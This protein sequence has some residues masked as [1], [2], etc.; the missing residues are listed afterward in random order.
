MAL[1][2]SLAGC[3]GG[4]TD[5]IAPEPDFDNPQPGNGGNN[6]GGNNGGGDGNQNPDNPSAS[7]SEIFISTDKTQLLTGKDNTI[8]NIRVTDK[9]GGIVAGVPVIINIAGSRSYGL[10][11]DGP[12]EQ[13]TDEKGLVTVE[14]LQSTVGIDSQLNH[15]TLLTVSI[16]NKSNVKQTFPIL[17]SGTRASNVVSTKNSVN[18]ND[19]FRIVGQIVDGADKPVTNADVILFSNDQQAGTGRLDSNGNFAFDLSAATLTPS[20]DNYIFSIEVK[21]SAI[22][23]RIPDI[24]TI[25]STNPSNLGFSPVNDIIV[26]NRQVVVLNVPDANNGDN[27]TLST[28]KGEI[29]VSSN[30]TTGSSRRILTVAN[31]QVVFYVESNVPGSA[32]ITAEYGTDSKETVLS[33]VSIQPKKLILQIERNV[34]SVGSATSVVA[35]VLDKDDAPVKNA[36]VQFT[37]IR[38][39]SGGNLSKAVAITNSN[40]QAMVTY[41]AGQNSTS[42]NGVE[43]K[44]QVQ[45]IRL[46]NGQEQTVNTLADNS[47]ITVQTRSTF[48]SFAFA[49]KL[50]VDDSEIYYFRKGSVSVLNSTGKPAINQPVSINL[51]PYDYYKGFYFVDF[52]INGDKVWNRKDIRCDKEDDNDNGILDD[53]EDFNGNGQLDPVN[54]AAII[55]NSGQIV[56]SNQNFNF[57]TDST[58]RVDFSV[59][60]PKEYA[61][62]YRAKVTVNTRV[63]GSESQQSRVIDFPALEDDIDINLSK[64]PNT[65]SPFGIDFSSCLNDG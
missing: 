51:N 12:S 45:S 48:I 14:L 57:T 1:A 15:E 10:S 28:N 64:R 4:G 47:N 55:N 6:G 39:S 61:R 40:G 23:Q 21:G 2:L 41:N 36:I 13:V 43:I 22:S 30:E 18:K 54:T 56:G 34:L 9:N 62:W 35:R 65:R 58:G 5:T 25:V 59:R 8:V 37:T 29:F 46:P 31:K 20:N 32:T 53:G 17:V 42:T 50:S 27:V 19:N 7:A 60:Y 63:D 33:Y 3:G 44:A 38:D 24:L 16:K 11:L 52:D 49:D 26:G